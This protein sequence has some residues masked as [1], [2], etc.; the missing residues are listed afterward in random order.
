[1]SVSVAHLL[2]GFDADANAKSPRNGSRA[3]TNGNLQVFLA[4]LLFFPGAGD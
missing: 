2:P 1:M 3:P 4:N